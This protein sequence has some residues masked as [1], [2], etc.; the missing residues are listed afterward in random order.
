[1]QREEAMT[2]DGMV[3]LISP[4][5]ADPSVLAEMSRSA[6]ERGQPQAA[7]RSCE[8]CFTG[9]VGGLNGG[10][11]DTF[12]KGSSRR[13]KGGPSAERTVSLA[14][15]A[16]VAQSLRELGHFVEEVD[17]GKVNSRGAHCPD[18][19]FN[20]LHGTFGEDGSIQGLLNGCRFPAGEGV[21]S[22]HS[23]LINRWPRQFIEPMGARC[24]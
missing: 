4:L 16:A 1:M 10:G 21:R 2:T 13:P 24:R 9:D 20:A 17:P 11:R 3:E 15:G 19:V 14:T 5:L 23:P 12:C 22:M 7:T 6:R 18:V 8:T